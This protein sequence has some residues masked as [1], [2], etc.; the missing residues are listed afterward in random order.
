MREEGI[1]KNI[2]REQENIH[3]N[4]KEEG[5]ALKFKIT[6]SNSARVSQRWGRESENKRQ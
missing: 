5:E 1:N 4:L 6:D 3:E 2:R